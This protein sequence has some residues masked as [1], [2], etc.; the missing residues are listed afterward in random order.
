MEPV[1]PWL[2]ARLRVDEFELAGA[3][4]DWLQAQREV[5]VPCALAL[6]SKTEALVDRPKDYPM[7]SFSDEPTAGNLC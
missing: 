2:L 5:I 3:R 1:L 4:G 6:L 7:G